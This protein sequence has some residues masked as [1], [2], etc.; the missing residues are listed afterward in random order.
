VSQSQNQRRVV[1]VGAGIIGLS[2]AF[3]LQRSGFQVQAIHTDRLDD[4]TAC[5]SAGA[6]AASAILPHAAPG[7]LWK[8][9][10]WLFDPLG[11]LAIRWSHVP[12]FLPWLWHFTAAAREP[13]RQAGAA[14]LA[15]LH[16]HAFED[17]EVV[18]SD[19]GLA[20]LLRKQG[21]LVVYKSEE[22]RERDAG[23]RELCGRFGYDFEALSPSELQRLEPALGPTARCG[24]FDPNWAHFVDPKALLGGLAKHLRN[25]GVQFFQAR[26]LGFDLTSGRPSAVVTDHERRLPGDHFV[27]AAGAWSAQLSRQL[28][29]PFPL[30]SERGYNTMVPEP[31][32]EVAN[33]MTFAEEHFVL[34]PMSKGLR[35]GGAAEFAGVEA[36]PNFRRSTMLLKLAAR[37]LPDLKTEGGTQWMGHRP[38][39]PD[40]VPVIGRS[41]NHANVFYAFGH[42]HLGLTGGPP[43]GRLVAALVGDKI[44]KIDMRPYRIDRFR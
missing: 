29:D 34:T 3:F 30:E 5:G 22:A 40:T 31:G 4:S 26:A 24:L 20:N 32:V 25:R 28:G 33:Y 38:Q 11:P 19:S 39:T 17:F 23:D 21:Q 9:P 1:I 14:A 35:I 7:T 42:G 27:I 44:P 6:I 41:T 13:K 10:K 2:V 16:R 8:V 12:R 15:A 18:L 43:T 37:Y 36:P